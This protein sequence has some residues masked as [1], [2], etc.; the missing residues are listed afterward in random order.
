MAATSW[1]PVAAEH[2]LPPNAFDVADADIVPALEREALEIPG[3]DV[4]LP[5][6]EPVSFD[7]LN[8]QT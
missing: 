6:I 7:A 4:E 3:L 1:D 8:R 2:D 5:T